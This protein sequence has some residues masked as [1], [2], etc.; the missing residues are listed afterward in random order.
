M[1]ER[2]PTGI[3]GLDKL[4]G[5]G[6]LPQTST[7]VVGSPGSGKTTFAMQFIMKG[8][9]DGNEGIFISLDEGKE[10][11]IRD[12]LNIGWKDILHFVENEKLTF[13]NATGKD[14]KTFIRR[15]LPDFASTWSGANARIAIDSLTP[16]LWAVPSRYEQRGL[17]SMM[18]RLFRK[19][20]PVVATLEEHGSSNLFS[21]DT[22]VP[23]YIGDTIIHLKYSPI[24][25][26]PTRKIRVIKIRGST[27][28]EGTYE[29]RIIGGFGI[30]ILPKKLEKANHSKVDEFR[31]KVEEV[32]KNTSPLVRKRVEEIVKRVNFSDLEDVDIDALVSIIKE[33]FY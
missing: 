13:V 1:E 8:L 9:R 25:D 27:H 7:V 12:A 29:Y 26:E 20:G 4:L 2:I 15:E 31:K 19:I 32:F 30:V 21:P 23:M 16:L 28:Y 33:E 10:Y 5:G 22:S 6:L 17:L 24:E 18:F 14:F 3:P 11:I